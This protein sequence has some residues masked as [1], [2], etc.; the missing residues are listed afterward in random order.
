MRLPRNARNG[1]P[2][3]SLISS[4]SKRMLPLT[5]AFG[6]SSL[7]TDIE[8]TDLPDP[9]SPT[10]ARTSPRHTVKLTPRTAG[11]VSPPT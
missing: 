6:A 7:S 5:R 10:R 8:L 11:T 4:P 3:S 9:D 2:C 1:S